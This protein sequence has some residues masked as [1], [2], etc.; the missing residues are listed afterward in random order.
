MSTEHTVS[1]VLAATVALLAGT[2]L[3]A[4]VY[5][6]RQRLQLP[7]PPGP[8]EKS[9]LGG[10]AEDMPRMYPW[11]K[12][13][14]WAKQYGDVMH[15]RVH[16]N[17][18]VV[19]S[20]Y[21]AVLDLF[22]SRGSLYSHRPRR[23]MAF[24]MGWEN[25]MPFHDYDEH[26]KSYRRY[27]NL[28]FSKKASV[29][30][31]AGQTRDVHVFLQ[32]VLANPD[33]FVKEFNTLTATIIMRVTYG[34]TISD[35]NDPH[36]STADQALASLANTGVAGHYLVDS[37]PFLRHLPTWLPGMGF[38]HKALEWRKL[39]TRMANEPFD[40]TRNQMQN[41]G[42]A[43]P[44]FLSEMLDQN[45]DG[46][47]AEDIIKWTAASMYG[48]GAHTTVG[49]LNNFILAMVLYPKVARKAREEIDRVVGPERLP[50]I[51]DRPDL[52][53]LECVLL[54][55]MRWYPVTPLSLPHRVK[56]DDAYRGYRIPANSTVYNNVYAITRDERLFPDPEKFI[57]ERFDESGGGGTPLNPKDII[58]GVGRRVCPGQHIADASI[59]LVMANLIATMDIT[60]ALDENGKEIEPAVVRGPSL[61]CQLRPFKCSIK[62]R[63]EHA[64]KLIN[65]AVMFGQE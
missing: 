43:V 52:P 5:K 47:E 25:I 58:F 30:Y 15:L 59:Y 40:W 4:R 28:G 14:E 33:A 61:I 18:I 64:V 56:E 46:V 50:G 60:K 22:E 32:R 34:Y 17:H 8:P 27:A 20:S 24:L 49:I 38:K 48:G 41:Q 37:Y 2:W 10:N 65:S 16:T 57:P 3:V 26:W 21:D 45:E 1:P 13:A 63:S 51:P 23:E 53:Y 55:T 9:W 42:K 31:Q 35:S 44:S 54:E 29:M 36:V 7:F 6:N 11:V 39:P 62:P 19:L 12:F